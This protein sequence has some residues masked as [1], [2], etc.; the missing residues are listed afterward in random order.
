MNEPLTIQGLFPVPIGHYTHEGLTP[1]EIFYIKSMSDKV[2]VNQ[3]NL[4]SENTYLLN[5]PILESF[6]NTLTDITNQFFNEVAQPEDKDL[7]LCITQSWVNF[8]KPGKYHHQHW[9]PNSYIS[10]VFYLDVEDGVD[11]I[12]FQEDPRTRSFNI[13][14]NNWHVYNSQSWRYKVKK[15]LLLLFPSYLTHSVPVTTTSGVRT[16]ISFNTFFKGSLGNVDKLTYL[17]I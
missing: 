3:G 7:K 11:E 15:N 14:T 16:S 4:S 12:L 5:S 6:K 9:H 13:P 8:T 17:T 10:G 2:R 1:E